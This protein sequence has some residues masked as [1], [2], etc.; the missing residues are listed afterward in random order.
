LS[1]AVALARLHAFGIG[2]FEARARIVAVADLPQG[3]VL[4]MKDA[5]AGGLV[6]RFATASVQRGSVPARA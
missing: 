3:P 6:T 1:A 5:L 2:Y 4:E